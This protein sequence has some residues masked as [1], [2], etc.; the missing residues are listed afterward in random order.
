MFP[1]MVKSIHPFNFFLFL[2]WY[3]LKWA[4]ITYS[5]FLGGTLYVYIS[6]NQS[7]EHKVWALGWGCEQDKN[8]YCDVRKGVT[9]WQRLGRDPCLSYSKYRT[10]HNVYN[11]Q[12]SSQ[13]IDSRKIMKI[14]VGYQVLL[15]WS[16]VM[17]GSF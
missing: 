2:V 16:L 9:W 4:Q 10:T 12:S 1:L 8:E 3:P 13:N 6:I 5:T 15:G 11:S 7:Q 14:L 17:N